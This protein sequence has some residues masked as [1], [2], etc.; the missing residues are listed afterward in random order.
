[1][2][3]DVNDYRLELASKMGASRAVNVAEQKIED[4]M[5]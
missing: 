3:T 5:K 1:V 4:V 2:I